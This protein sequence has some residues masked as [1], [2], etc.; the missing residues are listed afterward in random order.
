M[1]K[2]EEQNDVLRVIEKHKRSDYRYSVPAVQKL[3]RRAQNGKGKR[4]EVHSDAS[5]S[6]AS[7]SAGIEADFSRIDVVSDGADPETAAHGLAPSATSSGDNRKQRPPVR[8][9]TSRVRRSGSLQPHSFDERNGDDGHGTGNKREIASLKRLRDEAEKPKVNYYYSSST[10][11]LSRDERKLQVLVGTIER[12]EKRKSKTQRRSSLDSNISPALLKDIS[13]GLLAASESITDRENVGVD[14]NHPGEAGPARNRQSSSISPQRQGGRPSK[15]RVIDD[16]DEDEE[17]TNDEESLVAG[18]ITVHHGVKRTKHA[19]IDPLDASVDS[20][21]VKKEYPQQVK[22]QQPKQPKQ[23]QRGRSSVITIDGSSN[24][25]GNK[26]AV[27]PS[28]L[29]DTPAAFPT[30]AIK[31]EP[32]F[33]QTVEHQAPP[34]TKPAKSR[35]GGGRTIV[36]DPTVR[37]EHAEPRTQSSIAAQ[38]IRYLPL[39]TIQLHSDPPTSKLDYFVVDLQIRLL[40]GM[41]VGTPKDD[42]DSDNDDS[43]AAESN[44]LFT[45]YPSLC[46]Q[47]VT[48]SQKERLWEPLAGMFVSNLQFIHEATASSL[49]K[50]ATNGS[51]TP[52]PRGSTKSAKYR[53]NRSKAETATASTRT[54]DA[55]VGVLDA[56]NELVS[57]FTLHEKR[58]FVALR[59]YFVKLDEVVRIIRR[60][61]PQVSKQLITI[62]LDLSSIGLA[63]AAAVVSSHSPS[64]HPRPITNMV[65]ESDPASAA[66]VWNGPQKMLPL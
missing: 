34:K 53:A 22:E 44:P 20:L 4:P 39:Y 66:P 52:P 30:V 60:D 2:E 48:E 16:D 33:G 5:D 41:R 64:T 21:L 8:A 49:T 18:G 26:Q 19:T 62:T 6:D 50:S 36:E 14:V 55:E 43:R 31:R 57:Q 63:D 61:F 59:L 42:G 25:S 38:A 11:K 54:L 15:K 27:R 28:S 65:G 40:L 10:S 7:D 12:M 46:R 13:Y 17:R 24:P 45:K 3:S 37:I 9:G 51:A 32:V 29:F 47:R 56:D 35:L 58:K 1:A 23:R